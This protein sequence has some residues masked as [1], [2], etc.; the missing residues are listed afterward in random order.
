MHIIHRTLNT[1][2]K[3]RDKIKQKQIQNVTLRDPQ[4]LNIESLKGETKH[5]YVK[6]VEKFN[7]DGKTREK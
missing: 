4:T 2:I 1:A 6:E 7:S 3:R 5:F